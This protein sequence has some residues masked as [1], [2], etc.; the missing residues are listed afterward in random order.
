MTRQTLRSLWASA[1]RSHMMGRRK[2][3]D[4]SKDSPMDMNLDK[5]F[6]MQ[7]LTLANLLEVLDEVMEMEGR[8]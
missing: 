1:V 4:S 2:I 8:Q 7:K 3:K 6:G 5:K